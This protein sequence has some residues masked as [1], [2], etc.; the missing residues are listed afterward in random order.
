MRVY[1]S[2]WRGNSK[3]KT[4]IATFTCD[5]KQMK[6]KMQSFEQYHDLCGLIDAISNKI[7][8]KNQAAIFQY[9]NSYQK[10]Y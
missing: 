5:D 8:Q 7:E 9:I 10:G 4:G 3:D 6:F 2:G 1:G